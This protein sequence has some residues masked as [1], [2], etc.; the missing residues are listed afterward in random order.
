MVIVVPSEADRRC[1]GAVPRYPPDAA[2]AGATVRPH[3]RCRGR[4]KAASAVERSGPILKWLT[5]HGRSSGIGRRGDGAAMRR[6]SSSAK[7]AGTG[8]AADEK[9]GASV[10]SAGA[11]PRGCGPST[12][13]E[14]AS[15]AHSNVM[16]SSSASRSAS[17]GLQAEN[18]STTSAATPADTGGGAHAHARHSARRCGES[19]S[20]SSRMSPKIGP[21]RASTVSC[22]R[23]PNSAAGRRATANCAAT[24]LSIGSLRW[25]DSCAP[26]TRACST[27]PTASLTARRRTSSSGDLPTA[28]DSSASR[29]GSIAR[30]EAAGSSV[31]M[32][33]D[34]R[35]SAR[36]CRVAVAAL[37][38][39]SL[40]SIT[41]APVSRPN[42][43]AAA[44]H[45]AS[46][47]C[48]WVWAR[49]GA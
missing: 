37:N 30:K 16:A 49:P 3:A 44:A 26:N 24:F 42:A 5:R 47:T 10:S 14:L 33:S 46:H 34:G 23:G 4:Q 38:R 19:S 6:R 21:A 41:D 28:A 2:S 35:S 31:V 25:I 27:M 48:A 1:R 40:R 11:T 29:A 8:G 13:V 17:S 43:T 45:A 32:M 39:S 18:R 15:V 20:P 22:A 9:V 36:D 12:Q 7:R